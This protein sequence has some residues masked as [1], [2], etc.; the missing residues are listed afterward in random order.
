MLARHGVAGRLGGDEFGVWVW[1]AEGPQAA[2][3][4]VEDVERAL[5]VE[6]VTGDAPL[7]LSIGTATGGGDVMDLV[8]A[9]DR[10]LPRSRR[11]TR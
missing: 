9:A 2:A 10:D 1:G 7:G 3:Q 6:L 5:P 11:S 4:I 8:E